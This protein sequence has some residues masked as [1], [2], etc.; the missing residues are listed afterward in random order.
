MLH[1]QL[2]S[3]RDALAM[4]PFLGDPI[5]D[6]EGKYGLRA[7]ALDPVLRVRIGYVIIGDFVVLLEVEVIDDYPAPTE[8]AG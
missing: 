4:V 6:S 7:V 3:V 2:R 8:D 5:W 1:R